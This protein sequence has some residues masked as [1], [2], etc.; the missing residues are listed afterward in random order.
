MTDLTHV[1]AAA[2]ATQKLWCDLANS[3]SSD[4][5]L[6]VK[7]AKAVESFQ[8]IANPSTILA[9]LDR[10]EAA[11]KAGADYSNA[12]SELVKE[13]DQLRAAL[14]AIRDNKRLFFGHIEIDHD[15]VPDCP[16]CI[17]DNALAATGAKAEPGQDRTGRGRTM[18]NLY[19]VVHQRAPSDSRSQSAWLQDG[20]IDPRMAVAGPLPHR[21]FSVLK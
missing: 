12:I 21:T 1:R 4:I 18:N 6:P 10:I 15:C 16:R 9:L 19:A 8:L 20:R 7:Y 5:A 2:E 17:L 11:E 14:E 13:R 3:P